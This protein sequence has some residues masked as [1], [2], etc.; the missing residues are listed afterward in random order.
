MAF[1]PDSS[2]GRPRYSV[3]AEERTRHNARTKAA[4]NQQAVSFRGGVRVS[5]TGQDLGM[6]PL[7]GPRLSPAGGKP[8]GRCAPRGA[9]SYPW[10]SQEELGG[11]FLGQRL[12][13]RRKPK[14]T[15]ACR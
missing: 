8:H 10:S 6:P 2:R 7:I 3:P 1:G 4:V 5:R 13:W 11:V 9:S 15:V 12:T 14:G